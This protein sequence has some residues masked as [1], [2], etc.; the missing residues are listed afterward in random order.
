MPKAVGA[1]I[2]AAIALSGEPFLSLANYQLSSEQSPD[3]ADFTLRIVWP[4]QLLSSP[5]FPG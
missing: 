1:L 4:K 3:N 5:L 2:L